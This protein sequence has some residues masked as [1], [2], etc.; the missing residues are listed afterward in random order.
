MASCLTRI[1]MALCQILTTTITIRDNPEPLNGKPV[2]ESEMFG[3]TGDPVLVVL[4]SA[5]ALLVTASDVL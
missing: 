1:G 2:L 5:S 4:D 3:S